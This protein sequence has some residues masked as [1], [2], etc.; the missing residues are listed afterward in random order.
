M[1]AQASL[2]IVAFC[3]FVGVLFF[4]L[5]RF[6]SQPFPPN[7]GIVHG[8]YH[9]LHGQPLDPSDD[10]YFPSDEESESYGSSKQIQIGEKGPTFY[11]HDR[12]VTFFRETTVVTVTF[13]AE[14]GESVPQI[15]IIAP[16]PTLHVAGSILPVQEVAKLAESDREL[17]YQF[18][19]AAIGS[20]RDD[21][22]IFYLD[23][24]T[25]NSATLYFGNPTPRQ[26]YSET[27]GTN[28]W[29]IS[30][31]ACLVALIAF[32]PKDAS[33]E[34][35]LDKVLHEWKIIDQERLQAAKSIGW[36]DKDTAKQ[37][38][39]RAAQDALGRAERI[40]M[41]FYDHQLKSSLSGSW[42][43]IGT[44]ASIFLIGLMSLVLHLSLPTVTLNSSQAPAANTLLARL[45]VLEQHRS[46]TT[47]FMLVG[48]FISIAAIAANVL[49]SIQRTK[50]VCRHV[51]DEHL[52]KLHLEFE[53]KLL[54]RL[55]HAENALEYELASLAQ[56]SHSL[57][58]RRRD[59][60]A[61]LT[62]LD[63]Q[64]IEA[65]EGERLEVN[66]KGTEIRSALRKNRQ[67]SSN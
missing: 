38:R 36:I 46:A 1:S 16:H 13:T 18:K 35:Q 10:R 20:L 45:T 44:L 63:N 34:Q 41:S 14:Y 11:A 33:A 22:L 60:T 27:T 29:W 12:Q 9:I 19:F 47:V 49:I 59:L 48:I 62:R 25:P 55:K 57:E 23:E 5:F 32:H 66:E 15:E 2:R 6:Y 42:L 3:F 56:I 8:I 43:V 31:F 50:R 58:N 51:I 37:E 39:H 24:K 28:L 26:I 67:S 65:C 64:V 7:F 17:K 21:S 4:S 40:I 52:E 54:L 30:A 53:E 61:Q